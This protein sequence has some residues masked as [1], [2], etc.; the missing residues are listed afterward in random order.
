MGNFKRFKF[1][2]IK[3]FGFIFSK[4]CF[5][6]FKFSKISVMFE[7]SVLSKIS[8]CT[9]HRLSQKA[10]SIHLYMSIHIYKVNKFDIALY[11]RT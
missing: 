8:Y 1:W 10:I 11:V 7:I 5:Y 3:L 4:I 9:V 6:G 2:E